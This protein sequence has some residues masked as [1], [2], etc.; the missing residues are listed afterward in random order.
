MYLFLR[1]K[2]VELNFLNIIYYK[3]GMLVI[4]IWSVSKNEI[5]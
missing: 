4:I 1:S 5:Y 2:G 3:F